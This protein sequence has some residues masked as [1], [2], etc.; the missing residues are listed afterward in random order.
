MKMK[1]KFFVIFMVAL[2]AVCLN[3]PAEAA[4]RKKAQNWEAERYAAF[5]VDASTGKILHQE[6]ATKSRH[7]ASLTKM[8]TLYLT[9]EALSQ[10]KI[11]LDT[12]LSVSAEAAKRPQTNLA[13]HAGD[14]I[15]VRDA[16][17]ALVIRSA[18]DVAVVLAENLAGSEPKFAALMTKRAHQLGMDGTTFKNASGLPN[19]KQIT[20]A[21]DLAILGI[22]LKKHYPQ[23]YHFF[24]KTEF[25]FNGKTYK[26][27]NM[28]V[29]TY[30]GADGLKTGFINASGFNLVTSATREEGS[31]VG[32][33][34]GGRTAVSRNQQ[35]AK[36]LD[37]GFVKMAQLDR[38]D[39]PK[40]AANYTDQGF[41]P[42]PV[43]KGYKKEGGYAGFVAGS[44]ARISSA[45]GFE[46]E[47]E[48]TRTASRQLNYA[49]KAAGKSELHR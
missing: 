17:L 16:I 31:L 49:P 15:A 23:Y 2:M 5:V 11:S 42:Y 46:E 35:M 28:L 38:G 37:R 6:N 18:N 48:N 33:V 1:S 45:A 25:T 43:S 20:T 47:A 3:A 29:L 41:A 26:T 14:K 13:L 40:Y 7:P 24:S 21:K 34:L 44:N 9:F 4:K 8:M 30:P 12:K 36:L 27:H 19:P 22:A 10:G 39:E 32:V